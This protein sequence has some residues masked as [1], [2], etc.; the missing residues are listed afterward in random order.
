MPEPTQPAISRTP[1][2]SRH[3]KP[4]AAVEHSSGSQHR[5]PGPTRRPS[6]NVQS[7]HPIS[8]ETG[9][10][11]RDARRTPASEVLHVRMDE[12]GCTRSG[13]RSGDQDDYRNG[14]RVSRINSTGRHPLW[15]LWILWKTSRS[16]GESL[17][18]GQQTFT[19]NT[20]GPYDTSSSPG[21]SRHEETQVV[22]A[23]RDTSPKAPERTHGG[24]APA[25]GCDRCLKAD[26]QLAL[27]RAVAEEAASGARV[28]DTHLAVEHSDGPSCGGSTV[29][30]ARRAGGSL[31]GTVR[32]SGPL[33]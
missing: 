9:R 8:L 25:G 1:T 18:A 2:R 13:F 31:S 6:P 15:I 12:T 10:R 5:Q 27:V 22:G 20:V 21:K 23:Q 32:G 7:A 4:P 16:T 29:S 33:T 11:C 26:E 17:S 24:R 3:L 14:R 19:A 30:P 28:A